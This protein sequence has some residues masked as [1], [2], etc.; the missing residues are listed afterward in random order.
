MK[1]IAMLSAALVLLSCAQQPQRQDS[2]P[3]LPEAVTTP[4]PASIENSLTE[5]LQRG[6]DE[7]LIDLQQLL[8][9]L[10]K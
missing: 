8:N 10:R 5:S 4:P 9:R 6:L 7:S 3:P 1:I 2:S